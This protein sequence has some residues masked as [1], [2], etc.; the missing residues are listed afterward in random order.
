MEEV[1]YQGTTEFYRE[2][3]YLFG[4]LEEPTEE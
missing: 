1:Y 4:A 2:L 3:W